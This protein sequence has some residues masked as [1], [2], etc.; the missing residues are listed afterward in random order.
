MIWT[1]CIECSLDIYEENATKPNEIS[2]QITTDPAPN[3]RQRMRVHCA[4]LSRSGARLD[5]RSHPKFQLPMNFWWI[6][7]QKMQK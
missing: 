4:Q 5:L 7:Y 1:L 6:C 3:M 2:L